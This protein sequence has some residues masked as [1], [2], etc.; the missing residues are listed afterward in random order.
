MSAKKIHAR[1]RCS[2]Y[3]YFLFLIFYFMACT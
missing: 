3:I 2:I 1:L